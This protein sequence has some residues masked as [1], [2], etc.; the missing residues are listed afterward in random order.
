MYNLWAEY[1]ALASQLIFDSQLVYS[2]LG[3]IVSPALSISYLPIA[4]CLMFRPVGSIPI[5][6]SIA[7]VFIQFTFRQSCWWEFMGVASDVSRIHNLIAECWLLK[8]LYLQW[9]LSL[10]IGVWELFCRCIFWDWVP[11]LCTFSDFWHISGCSLNKTKKG[12]KRNRK[13]KEQVCFAVSRG[14]PNYLS[15][16]GKG[17]ENI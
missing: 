10:G 8:F 3:K 17:I 16:L 9:F 15:P 13:K 2:F 6:M 7:V 14:E 11:H 5:R 12:K 4:H 1:W